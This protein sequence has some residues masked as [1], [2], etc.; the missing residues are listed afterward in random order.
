MKR[1]I[2]LD[3]ET[4]GLSANQGDRIVEIGCVELISMRKG[5]TR[6]WY[7]NP[8][9]DIPEE[10]TRIHG[11]TNEKVADAPTF[12]QVATEFLQFIGSDHLVIHNAPFDLGFLNAELKRCKRRPLDMQRVIDTIPMARRKYPGASA[13]LDAL[14]KRFRIDNSHREFHGAL[15]D[16]DL[17][18]DVYVELM[19]GNQLNLDLSR[20]EETSVAQTPETPQQKALRREVLPAREWAV[21]EMEM[22]RHAAFLEFLQDESGHC[23]WTRGGIA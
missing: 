4:T 3:T 11:I 23:I 10:A 19:G 20:E 16:A 9:R 7:V 18:A 15:L 13:S 1:I 2:T 12:K 6:Q 5:E 22:T 8:E 21:S 17:L 14:C